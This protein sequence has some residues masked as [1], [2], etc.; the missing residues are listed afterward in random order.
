MFKAKKISDLESNLDILKLCMFSFEGWISL[1]RRWSKLFSSSRML[2]SLTSTGIR[3]VS[4]EKVEPR[5]CL[6]LQVRS[7]L[8]HGRHGPA[9]PVPVKVADQE[10]VIADDLKKFMSAVT[11]PFKPNIN[12]LFEKFWVGENY[13]LFLGKEHFPTSLG[14][15]DFEQK[16][17]GS[18]LLV[19]VIYSSRILCLSS[20]RIPVVFLS[21]SCHS[22]GTLSYSLCFS[23]IFYPTGT[24]RGVFS[25]YHWYRRIHPHTGAYLGFGQGG[26]TF[27]ADLHPP[28][29]PGSGSGSGEDF[30]LDPDPD[31]H[32]NNADPQPWAQL[33]KD[34][35]LIYN[36]V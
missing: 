1:E 18:P 29:P 33:S 28:P 8:R 16:F 20:C 25:S 35:C 26:C 4:G 19:Y 17:T 6:S 14:I 27:L 21:Y 12:A 13:E 9:R 15:I 11:I 3:E 34:C 36:Y 2:L 10:L 22:C 5:H 23:N 30:E 31:P 7:D 24:F 32:Q